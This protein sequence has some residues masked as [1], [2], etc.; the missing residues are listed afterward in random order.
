MTPQRTTDA[1]PSVA[2]VVPMYDEE[3]GASRCVEAIDAEL[4]RQSVRSALIVVDD[5]SADGTRAVLAA[6]A[7]AH[8]RLEVIT[9]ER[10]RGYGA[11]LRSGAARAA[12]QGFDYVLFMDSDLTN[13]PADIPRFIEK[14]RDGHDLIKASRYVPGGST[15]DVPAWRV[16]VSRV[17][18]AVATALFRM[19]LH[20]FTNGFRAVRTGVFGRMGLAEDGF[21]IIM[22]EVYHARRMRCRV[23]EVPV[24]LRD[25]AAALRRSSFS[26]GPRALYRYLEYPFR[27]ALGLAPPAARRAARRDAR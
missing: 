26:Y 11:A 7:P 6:L 9:H 3:A 25:R 13:D 5:G 16:A 8:P 2:V 15:S 21:S 18:N 17:G 24:T 27:S 14:M 23:A 4:G 22:E 19:P 12:Q 10:N 20:D 1:D